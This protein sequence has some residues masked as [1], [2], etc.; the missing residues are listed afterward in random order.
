[1]SKTYL[2]VLIFLFLS[3]VSLLNTMVNAQDVSILD[4]I[5][6]EA[7]QGNA[8]ARI[9]MNPEY[10]I[11]VYIVY[12]TPKYKYFINPKEC[13]YMSDLI[14]CSKKVGQG[15][16]LDR[17]VNP[18][19]DLIYEVKYNS[20]G[21]LIC[22]GFKTSWRS[23]VGLWKYYN[24][25]GKIDSIVNHEENRT[26]D[27]PCFIELANEFGLIGQKHLV[28]NSHTFREI[29][30]SLNLEIMSEKRG[31]TSPPR[32]WG[33]W[34]EYYYNFPAKEAEDLDSTFNTFFH[35]EIFYSK[36][37]DAWMA[38]KTFMYEYRFFSFYLHYYPAEKRISR[39]CYYQES[40]DTP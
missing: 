30:D 22:S 10:R 3:G 40:R 28:I 15:D 33:D 39:D 20:N 1:M 34:I 27:F 17:V 37:Y 9:F 31:E 4:S 19:I 29:C 7:E 13:F 12:D 18:A 26:C 2:S 16:R 14:F 21:L 11:P 23:S 32:K 6:K 25:N 38:V 36:S 35:T 5:K 24:Q 8:V